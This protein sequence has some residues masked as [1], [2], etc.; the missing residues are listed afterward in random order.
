MNVWVWLHHCGC[1]CIT[2]DVQD[3]MDLHSSQVAWLGASGRFAFP[4]FKH[5]VECKEGDVL[6]FNPSFLH[7]KE[8]TNIGNS[9]AVSYYNRK[10]HV[11]QS[12]KYEKDV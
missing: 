2:V 10:G 3:S 5:S 11:S 7:C 4:T 12:G 9:W 6:V 1:G 8:A